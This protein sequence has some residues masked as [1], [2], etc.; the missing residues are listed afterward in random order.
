MPLNIDD[1]VR[2][3]PYVQ[4]QVVGWTDQIGGGP[5]NQQST[6]ALG[7]YWGAAGVH[8]E[9]T[10]WKIYPDVEN[11][12]L[13]IHGLNNKISFF[14]DFR[15]AYSNQRLNT[16]AVQDDLDDNTYEYVRRYFAISSWTG[17]ILPTPVRS[18]AP[19]PAPDALADHRHDRHPGARS[20]RSSSASTS[21][22]R[23]SAGP[24]ASGGSSTR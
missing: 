11:E 14:A 20:T 1:V 19:D 22:S 6:G 21:G 7:R 3:V 10:A 23:P 13:N 8:T 5:F 12:I 15:A 4:G 24:R 18:P 17:G 16:I 9:I 2:V